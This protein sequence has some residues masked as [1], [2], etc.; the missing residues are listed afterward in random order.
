MVNSS[1]IS[2][3]IPQSLIKE[4]KDVSKKDHF[5]DL[6]EAVRSIIR[7]N[8]AKQKD[9]LSYQL[10]QV[11]K[12]IAGSKNIFFFVTGIIALNHYI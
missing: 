8:W 1:M 5:L 2:I 3:R 11:R 9:P 6:S 7:R 12:E 4:L 10:K